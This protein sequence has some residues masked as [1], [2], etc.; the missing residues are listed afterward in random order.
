ME[1]QVFFGWV[2][3][4][5]VNEE[6]AAH[7]LHSQIGMFAHETFDLREVVSDSQAQFSGDVLIVINQI[8]LTLSK[9]N[10]KVNEFIHVH[11]VNAQ[12]DEIRQIVVIAA[13]HFLS[14]VLFN[15]LTLSCISLEVFGIFFI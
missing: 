9:A 12:V 3:D 2:E 13:L 14:R 10:I 11:H 15:D 5:T 7:D 6:K 8:H 1:L 4:D